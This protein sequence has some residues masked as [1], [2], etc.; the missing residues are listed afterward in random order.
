RS[1]CAKSVPRNKHSSGQKNLLTRAFV[2]GEAGFEPT[3]SASRN[4]N[5]HISV[6]SCDLKPQVTAFCPTGRDPSGWQRM[7]QKCAKN[8]SRS[9]YPHG[10]P[11][12]GSRTGAA[13]ARRFVL[14][15]R[16]RCA[17][18]LGRQRTS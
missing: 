14:L 2:V 18:A 3:T 15:R 11:H 16:S 7:C 1:V 4:Q 9:R 6:D 12:F 13:N 17:V 8:R 10:V 5:T